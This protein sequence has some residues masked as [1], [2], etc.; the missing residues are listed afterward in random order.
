MTTTDMQDGG[1]VCA[2][3]ARRRLWSFT[4]LGGMVFWRVGRLGGSFYLARQTAKVASVERAIDRD[5][6]DA[7]ARQLRY[8]AAMWRRYGYRAFYGSQ[9]R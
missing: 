8:E 5:R 7:R 9:G 3:V 6:R 4:R 2:A 1:I